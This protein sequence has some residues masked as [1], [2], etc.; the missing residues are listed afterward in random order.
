ML[1]SSTVKLSS[2]ERR[3]AIIKAV[4]RV[5]AEKGFDGTT[6]RE[7]ANAAGVS[8]ALLFKHFP[9]KEALFSAMQLSCCTEQDLGHFERLKALEP[10]SSTLVLLVHFLVSRILGSAASRDSEVAMQN[11]LI[12]RSLAE[13][14]EFARLMLRC[15]ATDWIP[16]IEECLTVAAKTGDAV[17]GAILPSL[18][19]WFTHHLAAMLLFY[20]LPATPVVDYGVSHDKL[21]EQ[22][23]WFALRGMGLK[24]EAIK[25][26]Y[27]PKAL[28]LFVS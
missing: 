16:T 19:A 1:M 17:G 11:R 9:N 15:L 8:E 27:N 13:D 22:A 4:R 25:R 26:Y 28:A 23:V 7:L 10:S 6:T 24:E 5:F 12:L 18:R 14:G 20:S 21:V 2:E 3:V